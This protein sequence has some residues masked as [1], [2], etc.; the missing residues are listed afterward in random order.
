M[1]TDLS[2]ST[3]GIIATLSANAAA[4]VEIMWISHI[5]QGTQTFAS[6]TNGTRTT[7]CLRA[8][9]LAVTRLTTIS[10]GTLHTLTALTLGGIL[11]ELALDGLAT[12]VGIA[13]MS[14]QAKALK[15]TSRVEANCI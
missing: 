12:A 7:S 14:D 5:A 13:S 4:L 15:A 11:A 10:I 8:E 3:V 1:E 9:I 6:I 2:L